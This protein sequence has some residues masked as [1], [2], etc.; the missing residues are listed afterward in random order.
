MSGIEIAG[1]TLGLIPL[2]SAGQRVTFRENLVGLSSDYR[3]KRFGLVGQA[4]FWLQLFDPDGVQELHRDIN[5]WSDEDVRSW[6]A[7]SIQNCNAMSVAESFCESGLGLIPTT[8]RAPYLQ[9][10]A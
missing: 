8:D 4:L 1:A 6:K 3:R 7:S 10:L 9:V 2:I 5:C